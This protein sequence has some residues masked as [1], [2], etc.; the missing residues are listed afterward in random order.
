MAEAKKTTAKKTAAKKVE[1]YKIT[2]TNG[3]VIYRETQYAGKAKLTR[4]KAKGW[5]VEG[6]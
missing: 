2:K 4:M 1:R 6:V 5:K 3:K